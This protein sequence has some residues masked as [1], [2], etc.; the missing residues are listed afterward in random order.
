[1]LSSTI[2]GLIITKYETAFA[3]VP[4]LVSFITMLTGTGGNC[5]SQASTLVIR[6]LAMDEIELKDF[7]KVA[8][9][10]FRISLICGCILALVNGLRVLITYK[11]PTL[12]LLIAVS[13]V[14][15][16]IISKFIGSMLPMLATRLKLDPAIM[17]APLISTLVDTISI[18]VYFQL[19]TMLFG[20]SM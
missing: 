2:T 8:F 13:I 4:I 11:D 1:M 5:G 15:T 20:I 3:A 12:A 19:A 14:A 9:K 6:G 7:F 16:V 18:L 17:S 10:E